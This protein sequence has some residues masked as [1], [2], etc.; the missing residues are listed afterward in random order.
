MEIS[1]TGDM[2][3]V[4]VSKTDTLVFTID[5]VLSANQA[6]SLKKHFKEIFPDN[7]ILILDNEM[8]LEVLDN[9]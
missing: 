2:Q 7:K 1:F 9:A 6:A 5:A 8:E 3:K 4:T